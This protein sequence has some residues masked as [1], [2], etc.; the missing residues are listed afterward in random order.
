MFKTDRTVYKYKEGI[1]DLMDEKNMNIVSGWI[2]FKNKA[3]RLAAWKQLK[4]QYGDN[5]H[6]IIEDQIIKYS[7]QIE[8]NQAI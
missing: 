7:C 1:Y 3:E 2:P 8:R 4:R 6:I 5:I